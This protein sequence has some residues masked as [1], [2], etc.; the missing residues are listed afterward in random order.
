MDKKEF[1]E[2]FAASENIQKRNK[3]AGEM[4]RGLVS[5]DYKRDIPSIDFCE[6]CTHPKGRTL[7]MFKVCTSI[8]D[9]S[10]KGLTEFK[11]RANKYF[12]SQIEPGEHCQQ[13][14]S[15]VIPPDPKIIMELGDRLG[16]LM[17]MVITVY[18]PKSDKQGACPLS[19]DFFLSLKEDSDY[20]GMDDAEI[21]TNFLMN[22]VEML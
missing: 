6:V 16:E 18:D 19:E 21:F 13:I 5:F 10:I 3:K 8:D 22:F 9:I 11:G 1:I 15:L 14:L 4:N 12:E 20:E 17:N 7:N 2:K